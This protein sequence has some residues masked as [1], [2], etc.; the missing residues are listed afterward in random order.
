MKK[1]N[2]KQ[3][4]NNDDNEGVIKGLLIIFYFFEKTNYKFELNLPH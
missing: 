1:N 4:I 2:L 3:R